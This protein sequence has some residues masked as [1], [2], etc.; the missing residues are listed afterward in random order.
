[1]TDASG[2]TPKGIHA[3]SEFIC[4]IFMSSGFDSVGKLLC[5]LEG[6][7]QPPYNK[8]QTKGLQSGDFKD[9][10]EELSRCSVVLD[11][12]DVSRDIVTR[13]KVRL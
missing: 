3:E 5:R 10:P 7:W 12:R 1:M 4:R 9:P 8:D 11:C 13:H 2:K 6:I